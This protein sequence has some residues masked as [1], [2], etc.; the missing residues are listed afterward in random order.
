VIGGQ[1]DEFSSQYTDLRRAAPMSQAVFD[2]REQLWMSYRLGPSQV[3]APER[4]G[5]MS[6]EG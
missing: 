4:G 2:R 6:F 1:R 3:S 5:A